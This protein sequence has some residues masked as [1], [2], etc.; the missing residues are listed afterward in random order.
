MIERFR[1]RFFFE[2]GGPCLWAANG[3]AR[4]TFGYAIELRKLPLSE[5]T[6]RLGE[7][8]VSWHDGSLNRDYPPDPGPWRQ[9]ECDRFNRA[10]NAFFER[11]SNE[12]G[13][14]YELVNEQRGLTEDP[15]LDAYLA[16][17]KEFRRAKG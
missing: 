16:S 10:A 6:V 3:K 14:D 7:E 12:L 1:L 11:L 13:P 15:D 9:E 2:W 17:P 5:E 8:L 4:E